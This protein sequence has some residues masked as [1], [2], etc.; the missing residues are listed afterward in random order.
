[1]PRNLARLQRW[2]LIIIYAVAL[3]LR[4]GAVLQFGLADITNNNES[5]FIANS[6]ALGH[7]FAFD[8][9]GAR[10]GA[11]L[12]SFMPPLYPFWVAI[13]FRYFAQPALALELSQAF[14]SSLT[15]LLIDRIATQLSFRRSIGLLAA[16][17]VALYPP[18][19]IMSGYPVT[20]TLNT[21]L[22]ALLFRLACSVRDQPAPGR[23]V[24]T[25]I[26]LG[27][28]V[29]SRPA[30]IGLLAGLC[31][32][33]WLSTAHAPPQK[34]LVIGCLTAATALTLLPWTV[35]NYQVQGRFVFIS[36]NGGFSFWQGNNSFTTG[37]GF[38]VDSRRLAQFLSISYDPH[39]P[40]V[41][42]LMPYAFPKALQP[43][44]S[45]M[46]ELELDRALYQAGADFWKDN[47]GRGLELVFA[48]LQALWWFGA[49]AGRQYDPDWGRYYMILYAA[50]LGIAFPGWVISLR[51]WRQYL[52]LYYVLVYFTLT[53][54]AFNG[55]VRY[56][57]EF[58]PYLIVL[59]AVAVMTVY[60]AL[61]RN[62][63]RR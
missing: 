28:L 21:F 62:W 9:F 18:F 41:A 53:Y 20:V 52:F 44:L 39:Q 1:M 59:A 6:L 3:V 12:L 30:A 46:N 33:L 49:N 23:A 34:A 61:R 60:Q 19:I 32:W 58:E 63:S 7:G 13:Y 14:L 56:R 31:L 16:A 26:V 2:A 47:P 57:W 40:P 35:R 5:V 8:F 17:G 27:V 15:V 45:T 42:H 22:L 36:T 50:V 54:V 25:G 43:R 11:P 48:K 51:D 24:I 10:Q 37:N 55:Q 38:E 4:M 29:L